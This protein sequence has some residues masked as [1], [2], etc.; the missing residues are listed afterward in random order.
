M[1][2]EKTVVQSMVASCSTQQ[3]KPHHVLS[4]VRFY[5]VGIEC[6]VGDPQPLDADPDRF[7]LNDA[8]EDPDHTFANEAYPDP[9]LKLKSFG[10]FYTLQLPFKRINLY[11]T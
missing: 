10:Y 7:F 9:I 1:L 8:D 5:F 6:S 2:E 11:Y 4:K 3:L